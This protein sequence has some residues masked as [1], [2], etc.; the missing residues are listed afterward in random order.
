MLLRHAGGGAGPA[1]LTRDG[2]ALCN[3][4][5]AVTAPMH[6]HVH[7]AGHRALMH[8]P[9]EPTHAHMYVGPEREARKRSPG[10]ANVCMPCSGSC[11]AACAQA[12]CGAV[13]CIQCHMT[14]GAAVRA[15]SPGRTRAKGLMAGR[16]SAPFCDTSKCTARQGSCAFKAIASNCCSGSRLHP[17]FLP[18]CSTAKHKHTRAGDASA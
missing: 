7:A 4:P 6:V 14:H 3:S 18:Q 11:H 16:A 13:R 10:G 1:C 12:A 8:S 5:S 15:C 9:T 17:S 2:A